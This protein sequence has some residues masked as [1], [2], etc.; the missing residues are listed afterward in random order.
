VLSALVACTYPEKQ[1]DGPFTCLGAPPATT[2]DPLVNLGG[3]MIDPQT[4]MP[5][6]GVT[7]SL[8]TAQMAT[9]FTTTSDVTGQF[10]IPLN[11]NGTPVSGIN[12]FASAAGKVDSY[13]FPSRP[14]AHDLNIG[15]SVLSTDE[16]A[17]LAAGA[18]LAALPG[19]GTVLLSLNDCLDAQIAGGTLVSSPPG[20]VRY[21]DSIQPSMT[22]TMTDAGGVAMV[23]GLSPGKVTLTATVGSMTLPPLDVKTVANAFT[24]TEIQP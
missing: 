22:A 21:F 18:G 7:V 4:K 1:F 12:L 8:Q 16:A 3:R 15:L 23:A 9:I 14:I 5:V 20:T 19:N 10:T 13:Y 24:L 2:A 11:T 6:G 17:A